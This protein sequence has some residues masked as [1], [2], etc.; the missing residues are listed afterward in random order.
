MH[1]MRE[2]KYPVKAGWQQA[3]LPDLLK[4]EIMTYLGECV[5]DGTMYSVF[6]LEDGRIIYVP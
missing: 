6:A 1:S 2:R 3:V 5:I 4:G